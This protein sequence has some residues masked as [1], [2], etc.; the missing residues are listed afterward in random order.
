MPE[1]TAIVAQT[2]QGRADAV[3]HVALHSRR[4]RAIRVEAV[5]ITYLKDGRPILAVQPGPEFF[6]RDLAPHASK[7]ERGGRVEWTGICLDDV[8][9]GSDRVR[10]ELDLS[11]PKGLRR[12]RSSE[13]VEVALHPAP[14]PVRLRLPFQGYWRV[15]QGHSCRSRHRVGGFGENFAYDFVHVGR[16]P[17]EG[18]G[19]ARR[20]TEES[21]FG[22]PLF[23]PARGRVVRV[24][25]DVPDNDP[26]KE[27]RG[28]SFLDE[29]GT[30]DRIFGNFVVL[31]LGSGAFLLV[32]H[33]QQG[34]V[35]VKPG[36]EIEAGQPLARCGNS[37]TTS[38]PHVHVQ[39]MSGADPADSGVEGLPARF[40]GYREIRVSND[41]GR[42]DVRVR[43]VDEGDPPEASIVIGSASAP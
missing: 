29:L 3:V 32:A 19:D 36:D 28:R 11:M 31:D 37:G 16:P 18:S 13:A 39:V 35:I 21:S 17:R 9:V 27:P 26:Q 5:R 20:D 42:R 8:P 25:D 43:Q 6:T 22:L 41:E 34:S 7:V 30:P 10:L 23:S 1:P 12:T 15:V 38:T 40:V 33:L 4:G 2:E 14:P 24:V